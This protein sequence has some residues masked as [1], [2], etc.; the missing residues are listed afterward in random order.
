MGLVETPMRIT[1]TVMLNVGIFLRQLKQGL[2]NQGARHAKVIR[3]FLFGQVGPRMQPV[4]DDGAG[5]RIHDV[6]CGGLI[7]LVFHVDIHF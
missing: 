2:P 1:L 5:Q 3:Q 4:L 6:A 7:V